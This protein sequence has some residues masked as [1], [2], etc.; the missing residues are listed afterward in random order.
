MAHYFAHINLLS[1]QPTKQPLRIQ[2][3]TAD[4]QPEIKLQFN[5][6]SS[7]HSFDTDNNFSHLIANSKNFKYN[8]KSYLI[9]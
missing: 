8:N 6:A 7:L 9:L 3:A 2:Q 5:C 1:K 4:N